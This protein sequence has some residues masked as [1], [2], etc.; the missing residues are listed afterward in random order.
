MIARKQFSLTVFCES[1]VI[2]GFR[3]GLDDFWKPQV[4]CGVV[5]L[6]E[7]STNVLIAQF[8][9]W[10]LAPSCRHLTNIDQHIIIGKIVNHHDFPDIA[11]TFQDHAVSSFSPNT[12]R[13]NIMAGNKHPNKVRNQRGASNS[14]SASVSYIVLMTLPMPPSVGIPLSL[15][16]ASQN[17]YR[18]AFS[19]TWRDTNC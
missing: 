10:H 4:F 15:K 17:Q 13:H 9:I 18:N 19:F 7:L 16:L 8:S 6:F 12:G 5:T 11:E 2:A 1:G 3:T 14:F